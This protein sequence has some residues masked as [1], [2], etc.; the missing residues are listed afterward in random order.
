[1]TKLLLIPTQTGYSHS[2]P[3][4]AVRTQLE[5]GAGRYRSDYIGKTSIVNVSFWCNATQHDYFWAFYRHSTSRGALS[6]TLDMILEA[7]ALTTYTAYFIPGS[8]TVTP[9][10]LNF[11]VS[12]QLEVIPPAYDD[13]ADAATV[14]SYTP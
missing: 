14:A 7:S 4:D 9:N 1:M 10:A 12:C 13:T 8:I 3:E 11:T 6:F 2:A 5:G